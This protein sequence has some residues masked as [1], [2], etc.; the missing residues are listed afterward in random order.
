MKYISFE[1]IKN[2][3][4]KI[5]KQLDN[6]FDCVIGIAKG[7]AIPATLIAYQLSTPT[8]KTVQIKSYSDD[9]ERYKTH[10]SSGT[11]S[12][13]EGLSKY[14]KVLLV[15]DLVDSGKTL[16]DF[17]NLYNNLSSIITL[18]TI[19]TA[20]LFYKSK[21]QFKPDYYAEEIDPETWLVFPWENE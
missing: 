11:L 8:F 6:N 18:P 3:S 16:I 20:C 15:D 13:F 19:T 9:K 5:C 21:S 2:H 17:M 7:G 12:L 10:F 14:N 4:E 1:E